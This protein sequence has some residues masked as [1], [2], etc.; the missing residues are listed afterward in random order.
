MPASPA[1]SPTGRSGLF[2]YF[3]NRLVTE[4]AH[5]GA[6]GRQRGRYARPDRQRRRLR[7]RHV[8]DQVDALTDDLQTGHRTEERLRDHVADER[9]QPAAVTVRGD[10]HRLGPHE[11]EDPLT[12]S[13]ASRRVDVQRRAPMLHG[14]VLPDRALE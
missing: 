14:S 1:Y 6:L 5:A 2:G 9:V 3:G 8:G 13:T 11:D 4:L 10:F 12:V 7:R